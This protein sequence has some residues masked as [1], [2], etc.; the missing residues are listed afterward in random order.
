MSR[1][2]N[3][4]PSIMRWKISTRYATAI[5][6][7]PRVKNG[8]AVYRNNGF[9][10]RQTNRK[11]TQRPSEE[12]PRQKTLP[13]LFHCESDWLTTIHWMIAPPYAFSTVKRVVHYLVTPRLK[14]VKNP[15][16]WDSSPP[17]R[18]P[19][20]RRSSSQYVTDKQ[21]RRKEYSPTKTNRK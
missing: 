15:Y 20:K 13:Q 2:G 7:L 10:D 1:I 9:G 11:Q 3:I 5:L 18:I 4:P 12:N 17:N 6:W 14:W 19:N 8:K 16:P 21:P